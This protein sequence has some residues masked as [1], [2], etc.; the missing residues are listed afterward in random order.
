MPSV[1][2]IIAALGCVAGDLSEIVDEASAESVS[3]SAYSAEREW[4][5][6]LVTKAGEVITL[7]R[8]VAADE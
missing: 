5:V 8:R 6:E 4:E 3:I 1:N 7:N 2:E